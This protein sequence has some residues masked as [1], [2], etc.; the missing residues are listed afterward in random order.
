MTCCGNA[1][2]TL[3]FSKNIYIYI[4]DVQVKTC[5][6]W[7]ME[8]CLQMCHCY[9]DCI[10]FGHQNASWHPIC[11]ISRESP[12]YKKNGQNTFIWSWRSVFKQVL[13]VAQHLQGLNTVLDYF[14]FHQQKNVRCYNQKFLENKLTSS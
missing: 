5:A 9:F 3:K 4:C 14:Q 8:R 6:K 12:I 11:L 1:K 7:T 10:Y 13:M 2:F